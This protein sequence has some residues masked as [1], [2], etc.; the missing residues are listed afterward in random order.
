MQGGRPWV[1]LPEPLLFVFL[2]TLLAEDMAQVMALS[3]LSLVTAKE[4]L[5]RQMVHSSSGLTFDACQEPFA[6]C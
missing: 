2:A 4:E 5:A 1:F 6:P 3:L